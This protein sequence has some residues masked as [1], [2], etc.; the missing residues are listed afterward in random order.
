[1][2]TRSFNNNLEL[3]IKALSLLPIEDFLPITLE[4]EG[5][6]AVW[7]S[8]RNYFQGKAAWLRVLMLMEA[9]P[10]SLLNNGL[11]LLPHAEMSKALADLAT[12]VYV[13]AGDLPIV[14]EFESPAELW[15]ACELSN[16]KIQ[17]DTGGLTDSPALI[18]KKDALDCAVQALN[19]LEALADGMSVDPP[20]EIF[21]PLSRFSL[22]RELEAVA[23]ALAK[24]CPEF[25]RRH[26]R[27]Y[28]K[29]IRHGLSQIQR[30]K[31]LR[32]CYYHPESDQLIVTGK[33]KKL[34]PRK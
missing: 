32:L 20:A 33:G 19:W 23:L 29:A 4:S 28:L 27:P 26:Y 12:S 25:D 1:M 22:T 30:C 15:L 2:T 21:L 24:E 13:R 18:G 34:P 7:T 9:P 11:F 5:E 10:L 6:K 14:M 8:M 16:C 31:D 3:C 17:L